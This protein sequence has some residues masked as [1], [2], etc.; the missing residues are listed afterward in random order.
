MMAYCHCQR[1]CQR[2]IFL[3]SSSIVKLLLN[4][5]GT[6]RNSRNILVRCPPSKLANS[7]PSVMLPLNVKLYL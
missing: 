6:L 5:L 7:S 1:Q 3:S 2:E 4:I